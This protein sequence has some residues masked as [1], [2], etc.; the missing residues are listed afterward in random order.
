[1]Q[2]LWNKTILE[3]MIDSGKFYVNRATFFGPTADMLQLEMKCMIGPKHGFTEPFPG[4][5]AQTRQLLQDGK[6]TGILNLVA[7]KQSFLL[8][9]TLAKEESTHEEEAKP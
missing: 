5:T 9:V 8:D 3:E 4:L 1:M 2:A 6:I 7:D